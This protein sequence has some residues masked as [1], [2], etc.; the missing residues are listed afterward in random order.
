MYLRL[1]LWVLFVSMLLL[2]VPDA[3]AGRRGLRVD[4]GAWSQGIPFEPHVG[5]DTGQC[6]GAGVSASFAVPPFWQQGYVNR[7][8]LFQTTAFDGLDMDE[9]YCQHSQPYTPFADPSQYLNETSFPEDERDLAYMI[10]PNTDNAVSGIRY[11]FMGTN[12]QGL[13]GRQWVFYF[14][15]DDLM[16]VSLH[17]VPEGSMTYPY[18]SIMDFSEPVDWLIWDSE[19]DGFTGQ[20]FCFQDGEYIGD[21]VPPAPPPPPLGNGEELSDTLPAGT[22]QAVWHHYPVE[23]PEGVSSFTVELFDLSEDADLYVNKD[24]PATTS[25]YDCRPFQGGNGPETCILRHDSS[26][27]VSAGTWYVS[28]N[29]WTANVSI[30][31]SLRVSWEVQPEMLIKNGFESD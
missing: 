13:Y 9:F 2:P 20:Y 24:E 19:R 14:F 28:V 6:A 8:I 17:G 18:E 7:G 1:V 22:R 11:A 30:S 16:V 12:S 23:L 10:G 15:P 31:Y 21:C 4:F 25:D 26:P 5:P 3:E 27:A 29:N